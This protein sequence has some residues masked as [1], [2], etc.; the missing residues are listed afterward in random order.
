MEIHIT[1]TTG[2][3]KTSVAR[4]ITKAL[5]AHGISPVVCDDI[6]DREY[7]DKHLDKCLEAMKD[8]QV[9]IRIVYSSVSSSKLTVKNT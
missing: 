2:E 1:G 9:D 6:E 7:S 5:E 4:L 8:K 3:G